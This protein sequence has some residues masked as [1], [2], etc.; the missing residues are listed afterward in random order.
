VQQSKYKDGEAYWQSVLKVSPDR[1]WFHHFYGRY[2]FKQQD[3]AKF[4]L[5]LQE[6]LRLKAYGTFYYNLG[7]IELVQKKNYDMAYSSFTKAI[8]L[9]ET[10]PEVIKNFI[11]LCNES[12]VALSK[13]GDYAKA[14]ERAEVALKYDPASVET[15]MNLAFFYINLGKTQQAVALWRR[16]LKTDPAMIS[17][18]KNLCIYYTNSTNLEDSA[19]YF[20][21]QFVKF[22]GKA[23]ELPSKSSG[24]ADRRTGGRR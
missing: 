14:A 9:G 19:G 18:S 7:M 24:Q 15:L 12:A 16:V 10:N 23:A 5:Q 4:E 3:F 22:G 21:T 13:K 8:E 11:D 6:A 1:A 17:A 2:Y 20:A